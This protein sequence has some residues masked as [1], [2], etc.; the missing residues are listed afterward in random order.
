MASQKESG[1][2]FRGPFFPVIEGEVR[3]KLFI[4]RKET[5]SISEATDTMTALTK[6]VSDS[7]RCHISA[8]LMNLIIKDG[9]E[10]ALEI[11]EPVLRQLQENGTLNECVESLTALPN[12]SLNECVESSTALPMSS[13]NKLDTIDSFT[14]AIKQLK[15]RIDEIDIGHFHSAMLENKHVI[16]LRRVEQSMIDLEKIIHKLDEKNKIYE[17]EESFQVVDILRGVVRY[18]KEIEGEVQLFE[19]LRGATTVD[20]ALDAVEAIKETKDDFENIPCVKEGIDSIE[21]LGKLFYHFLAVGKEA[22]FLKRIKNMAID[23]GWVSEVNFS[24]RSTGS[25]DLIARESARSILE[26]DGIESIIAALKWWHEKLSDDLEDFTTYSIKTLF[27]VASE[28]DEG[29]HTLVSIGGIDTVLAAAKMFPRSFE[30]SSSTT[31]LIW[32]ISACETRK[33]AVA[34]D[35]CIEFVVRTM[36]SYSDSGYIQKTGRRYFAALGAPGEWKTS[37]E[38]K[39]LRPVLENVMKTFGKNQQPV[40]TDDDDR[41]DNEKNED[42]IRIVGG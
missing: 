23:I 6:A 41:D 16:T 7:F 30:V 39:R 40:D 19:G 27:S 38:E 15:S 10:T 35:E 25:T 12:S 17:A 28:F 18:Y 31:S 42:G 26:L 13:F 29:V 34:T 4:L 32:I 5:T 2:F 11:G 24:L 1:A 36:E 20:M 22:F 33:A 3:L 37:P 21:T 9:E 8:T 14:R